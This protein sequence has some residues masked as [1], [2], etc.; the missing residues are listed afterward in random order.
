[1]GMRDRLLSIHIAVAVAGELKAIDAEIIHNPVI[2][3]YY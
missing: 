3:K 1:M 2:D